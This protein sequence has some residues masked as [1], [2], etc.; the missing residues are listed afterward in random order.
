MANIFQRINTLMNANINDLLD[1]IEDPE[2]M[3]KQI[4]REME[5]NIQQAKQGVLAA[6]TS[7]KQLLQELENHRREVAFWQQKAETALALDK[8]DLARQAL[9][10]KKE[11][12]A[13]IRNLEP[14]WISARTTSERLKTQLRALEAKLDE[15]RR[16]RNT[17]VARQKA[18][19]A[20][21]QMHH[22]EQAMQAGLDSQLNFN[23]MED[24]IA[25]MEAQADAMA[26]L[27]NSSNE[28]EQA[29]QQMET[30]HAIDTEL[31][32]LKLSVKRSIG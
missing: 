24:K 31:E 23:R 5:E 26:E 9:T 18:S 13:I 17:L 7:E 4:I 20:R 30:D 11:Y 27:D 14:A 10:R 12:E 28:L 32:L 1:R 15:I 29:F 8:D 3:I 25:L 16:K 22:T 21:H 6:I 19:A 2:R